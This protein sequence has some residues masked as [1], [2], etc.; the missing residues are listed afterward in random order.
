MRSTSPSVRGLAVASATV[1]LA[2]LLSG[3]WIPTDELFVTPSPE[4]VP[5]GWSSTGPPIVVTPDPSIEM[6]VDTPV[7]LFT[8]ANPDGVTPG[9][10]TPSAFTV[11]EGPV[12]VVA[13]ITYHYVL[14]DGLPST[15]QISL[16]GP[17]GT[18][19]GPWP[20]T[21]AEGQGGI[22]NA[23]WQASV[24]LTLSPGTYTIIDSEP[25]TW[26]ANEGTGG[27]GMFWINGYAP[28][29]AN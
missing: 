13:V 20:T 6:S 19:F 9:A 16:R 7:M 22:A 11:G 2:T 4:P 24:D 12:H 26:S 14:P 10:T 15:G 29:A 8:N 3:C 27:A 1:A 17:D 28:D 23:S 25:A 5:S 18:V 21:G